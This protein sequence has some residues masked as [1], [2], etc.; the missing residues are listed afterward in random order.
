MNES[1]LLSK[2]LL[3]IL[4]FGYNIA[5]PRPDD[6]E[7]GGGG[8]GSVDTGDGDSDDSAEAK[9]IS[10][11]DF[12][13]PVNL[14]PNEDLGSPNTNESS[15]SNNDTGIVWRKLSVN[16]YYGVYRDRF[17]VRNIDGR[18]IKF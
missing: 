15:Y 1:K 4:L 17:F 16:K 5:N 2:L 8:G 18:T 6:D 13:D 10:P 12:F 9:C 7:D 14:V 11:G 3:L